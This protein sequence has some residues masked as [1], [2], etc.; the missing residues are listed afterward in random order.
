[1]SRLRDMTGHWL[2]IYQSQECA[3]RSVEGKANIP[4]VVYKYIPRERI[5]KGAPDSL[6]A[7]QILALN[8]D[9]ECN[10]ATMGGKALDRSHFRA[11]IRSK[12]KTCLGITVTEDELLRRSNI[13]GDLRLSTFIQ[14]FLNLRVGVVALSKDLL[15]PTMWAH[16]ARNT[17]IVVGLRYGSTGKTWVRDEI[18]DLF[19]TR[20]FVRTSKG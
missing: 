16:Y 10:I 12:V 9:M 18:G 15:V 17:G 5:G 11:L 1:M 8:D 19:R 4:D 6:R 7:T 13:Y 20:T 3:D 2:R 14:E